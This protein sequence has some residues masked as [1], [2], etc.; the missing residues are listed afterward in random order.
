MATVPL[1]IIT[2][3]R[4][5]FKGDITALVCRTE[6]GELG[7]L[8]GHAD[9]LAYLVP[10]E[11]RITDACGEKHTVAIRGGFLEVHPRKIT[12]LAE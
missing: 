4:V 7:I 9:L 6:V 11:V 3:E 1:E 12:V 5:L 10:G 2:P 8:P